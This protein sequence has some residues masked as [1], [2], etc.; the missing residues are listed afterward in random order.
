MIRAAAAFFVAAIGWTVCADAQVIALAAPATQPSSDFSRSILLT[1][2]PEP[3]SVYAP[4][5][6]NPEGEGLNEGGVY[7]DLDVRFMTDYI[8]RGLDFSDGQGFGSLATSGGG[9]SSFGQEDGLNLQFDGKITW[10]LGK[11]PHP[12]VELFVNVFD[13]DPESRFQVVQPTFGLEWN[14]RPLIVNIGQQSYIYP[15]RDDLNTAEIFTKL[16]LDDSYFFRTDRPILSPYFYAAYDY[17]LYDGWYFE[18]GIKHDFPIGDTGITLTGI[19][20]VAY[21]LGDAQFSANGTSDTGFQH[22]DL[23]LI[24]TFSMNSIFHFSRRYGEFSVKGY[25]FYTNG[26]DTDLLADPQVWGG[27]GIVFHY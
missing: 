15:E 16:T 26:I 3:P 5:S 27:A 14:L 22:Y 4:P 2:Q 24:G 19:A 10:D 23:G 9:T 1:L 25:L 21:V 8:Y 18:T 20:D 11:L 12:Y 13:S 6:A 17:D 7:V